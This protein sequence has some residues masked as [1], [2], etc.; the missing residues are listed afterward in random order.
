MQCSSVK[1]I[2]FLLLIL[3]NLS[4]KIGKFGRYNNV[5]FAMSLGLLRITLFEEEIGLVNNAIVVVVYH[6]C[7][8]WNK[9][10]QLF[11]I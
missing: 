1:N 3:K 8:I 10:F 7:S 11:L 5:S 9:V 4:S 2:K 6:A